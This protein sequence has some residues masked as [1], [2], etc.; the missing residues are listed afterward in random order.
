M[1][2]GVQLDPARRGR[3]R[4]LHQQLVPAVLVSRL[5]LVSRCL[6]HTRSPDE[7]LCRCD[8]RGGDAT[9]EVGCNGCWL[10]P[11]GTRREAGRVVPAR[12]GYRVPK[13]QSVNRSVSR[14][15]RRSLRQALASGRRGRVRKLPPVPP[16]PEEGLARGARQRRR[17]VGGEECGEVVATLH[18]R[19]RGGRHAGDCA[20]EANCQSPDPRVAQAA[21]TQNTGVGRLRV[22]IALGDSNRAW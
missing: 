18:G 14:R 20:R 7:Q 21:H 19:Q 1:D 16:L 3:A 9:S 15:G 22:R 6:D 17:R 13:V 2:G 4:R 10:A 11:A 5:G 12:A 8:S